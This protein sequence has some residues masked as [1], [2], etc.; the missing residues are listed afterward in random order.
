MKIEASPGSMFSDHLFNLMSRQAKK[1]AGKSCGKLGHFFALRPKFN[2]ALKSI[3]I[4]L[5]GVVANLPHLLL[6]GELLWVAV[7]QGCRGVS[8]LS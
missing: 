6:K 1:F 7:L 4:A 2:H 5:T 3:F 8:D